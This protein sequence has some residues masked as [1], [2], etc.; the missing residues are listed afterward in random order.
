[1]LALSFL[2]VVVSLL[3]TFLFW[4]IELGVLIKCFSLFLPIVG[5]ASFLYSPGSSYVMSIAQKPVGVL[6]LVLLELLIFTADAKSIQ[7]GR[8]RGFCFSHPY[9]QRFS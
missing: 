7:S 4:L 2:S 3:F 1:M 8:S 9:L 5:A 6:L